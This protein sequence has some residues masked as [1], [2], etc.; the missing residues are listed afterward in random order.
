MKPM[1]W[2]EMSRKRKMII[3]LGIANLFV[4]GLAGVLLFRIGA[5]PDVALADPWLLTFAFVLTCI[6]GLNLKYLLWFKDDP[7]SKK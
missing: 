5:R 1:K 2:K 3:V 7:D 6:G 4:T